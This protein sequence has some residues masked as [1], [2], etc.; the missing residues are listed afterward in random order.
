VTAAVLDVTIEPDGFGKKSDESKAHNNLNNRICLAE[1]LT[2][3]TQP[4]LK[5]KMLYDVFCVALIFGGAV[6]RRS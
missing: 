6:D 2:S 1:K 5:A 3:A 4:R